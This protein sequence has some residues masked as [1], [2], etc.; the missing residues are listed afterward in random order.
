MIGYFD[1]VMFIGQN[2]CLSFYAIDLFP[3]SLQTNIVAKLSNDIDSK[4]FYATS[5][6]AAF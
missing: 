4:L 1:R 6:C 3:D 5:K 2:L